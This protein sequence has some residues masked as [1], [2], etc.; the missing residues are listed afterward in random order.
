MDIHFNLSY[1]RYT[2]EEVS[3]DDSGDEE[4][5]PMIYG[6]GG[7]NERSNTGSGSPN[8]KKSKHISQGKG[9]SFIP[10]QVKDG[11]FAKTFSSKD[12]REVVAYY[13][14]WSPFLHG[15]DKEANVSTPFILMRSF[16]DKDINVL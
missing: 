14:V 3:L 5:F 11:D 10:G 15:V 1:C 4:Y 9:K 7:W 16:W 6:T 8:Q 2:A 12:P 13:E